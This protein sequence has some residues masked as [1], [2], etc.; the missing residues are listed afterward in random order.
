MSLYPKVNPTRHRQSLSLITGPADKAYNLK[1]F[2]SFFNIKSAN[3]SADDKNKDIEIYLDTVTEQVE[4]YLNAALI[5]QT[6]KLKLDAWPTSQLVT[7][8]DGVVGIEMPKYPLVSVTDPINIY[9]EDSALQDTLTLA[10]KDY[11]VDANY[12]GP[13]R[14]AIYRLVSPRKK[15]GGIEITFVAGYGTAYVNVPR[16]IRFAIMT[17][18][19]SIFKSR[20]AH[21]SLGKQKGSGSFAIPNNVAVMLNP[22][23]KIRL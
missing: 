15:L 8:P 5:T 13:G 20:V 4:L 1:E 22:Y 23:R 16:S 14:L 3:A 9:D 18:A 17:W 6:W 19:A 2:R 10:N 12:N 7:F 11:G 21:A